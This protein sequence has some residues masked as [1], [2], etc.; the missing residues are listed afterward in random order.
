VWRGLRLLRDE[1]HGNLV[2]EAQV[3]V[4]LICRHAGQKLDVGRGSWVAWVRLC[5]AI[6]RALH[7]YTCPRPALAPFDTY[8]KPPYI[9]GNRR[10]ATVA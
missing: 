10:K 6:L 2:A 5:V 8:I 7:R 3:L 9:Y 4:H 1:L